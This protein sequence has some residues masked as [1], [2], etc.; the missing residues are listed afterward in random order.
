MINDAQKQV[1]QDLLDQESVSDILQAM[2]NITEA[3]A[4]RLG[5]PIMTLGRAQPANL[6]SCYAQK[7]AMVRL[8]ILRKATQE[9]TACELSAQV[10]SPCATQVGQ[11]A[12]MALL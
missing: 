12:Q 9:A 1:L 8:Q 5:R 11:P 4:T 6:Q 2:V 3:E 7:R 10:L